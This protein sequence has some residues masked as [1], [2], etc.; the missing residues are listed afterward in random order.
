MCGGTPCQCAY[1][2]VNIIMHVY[3]F[4]DDHMLLSAWAKSLQG[5]IN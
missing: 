1:N 3:D 5:I 2:Y 4:R